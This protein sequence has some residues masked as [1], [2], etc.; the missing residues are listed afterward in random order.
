MD[1]IL[2]IPNYISLD[3]ASY[4]SEECKKFIDVN[5]KPIYNRDGDTVDIS[6]TPQLKALKQRRG[7]W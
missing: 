5:A 6:S 1:N 4:I 7:N 2:E 3:F